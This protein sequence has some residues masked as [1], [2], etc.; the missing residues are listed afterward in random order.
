MA[1]PFFTVI[2]TLTDR[3]SYLFPFTL[4][5]L[6]AQQ[7]S[8]SFE[9]IIVDGTKEGVDLS[10]LQLKQVKVLPACR[11]DTSAMLNQ[12]LAAAQ[13]DYIHCLNPGEYY[14]SKKALSFAAKI[15][16]AYDF[17]DLM[18][19]AWMTRHHFGQPTVDFQPL[20]F[21][22]LKKARMPPNL[23]PFWLRRETLLMLGG[24]SEKYRSKPATI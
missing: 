19:S 21:N 20:A 4:D 2:I 3:L 16:H 17:P 8:V 18:Y 23:Q 5:S 11:P 13:G 24:F 12:A 7:G 1:V 22:D 10:H 14:L 15:I 9:V 6:I